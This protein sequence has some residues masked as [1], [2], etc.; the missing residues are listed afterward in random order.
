MASNTN[1]PTAAHKLELRTAE[2][3]T[4]PFQR[5]AL[6][7]SSSGIVLVS[8]TIVAMLWSNSPY[9]DGYH[10]LFHDIE[11]AVGIGALEIH[12]HLL[13]WI[14]DALMAVFFLLVGLEIK[15]E[16]VVGELSDPR[17][18]ALPIFAA[19][20]GM[21]V[22][23]AIY[24]AINF[25][26]PQT[27]HGWGVPMATDI[28]FALGILALIGTRAPNSLKVFLAGLAIADDLGALLVIAIFY[29]EDLN[30]GALGSAGGV[31]AL[32]FAFNI[33]GFRRGLWYILPGIVLWY[34]VFRSGVHATIAGVLLAS[35]IP[36]TSRVDQRRYLTFSRAAL[37]TFEKNSSDR[38]DKVETNAAQRA[39]VYAISENNRLITPPLNRMED[40]LH[41]WVAFLVIPIFALA[42]A[43]VHI[44]GG[45]AESLSG[46]I[47]LG[48]ILGLFIGK[49]VG[50][51]LFA[52]ISVKLGIASL[53]S[54]VT[55]K[56]IIG[57]GCLG[58]IGFTMALF[59]SNLAFG[60][61][62][63]ASELEHAKVGILTASALSTILG[64]SILLTCKPQEEPEPESLGPE[65]DLR[66]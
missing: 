56:H 7:S 35:T 11:L 47:S 38:L 57:V 39:A 34:F 58:G 19:V 45:I 42:N 48:V 60:G 62:Q 53:P 2:R 10:H 37:D 21:L 3:L 4:K 27:M 36:V 22:P 61:P 43:G 16:L 24:A 63:L 54:G 40:T 8:C 5:F 23:A 18:A 55:W 33:I 12:N 31:L 51:T 1:I 32:L 6:L 30:W 20:G 46:P 26:N 65:I 9:A 13:H 41:P 28:A 66:D 64:L 17:R 52:W 25:N 50:I 29:T 15:R 59:I 49:P 14:N 44:Q